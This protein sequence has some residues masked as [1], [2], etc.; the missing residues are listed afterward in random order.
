MALDRATIKKTLPQNTR[1]EIED[2]KQ[3]TR[4]KKNLLAPMAAATITLVATTA[5][6]ERVQWQLNEGGNGHEYEVV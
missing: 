4:K 3:H 1:Q 6:A 2:M 5:L